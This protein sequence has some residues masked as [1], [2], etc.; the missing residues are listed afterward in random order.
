MIWVWIIAAIAIS[1]LLCRKKVAWYHYIWMLLPV[2]MYGITIAGATIKP[3]MILGVF[4]IIKNLLDRKA[5]KVPAAFVAIIFLLSV[6]DI[7]NGLIIASIMQHVMFLVI[8]YIAYNYVLISENDDDLLENIEVST[9]ATTIGYGLVFLVAYWF[10]SRG[11]GFGGIY[12]TDRYSAGMLLNFISTGGQTTVRLRGFCIDPNSVVTTLIPGA[13]FGL[14]RLLYKNGGKF[15]SLVAVIL[16]AIVM[17]LSGSRMAVVCTVAMVIIM[18]MMGYKQAENKLWWFGLIALV[19]LV[20]SFM[21][22]YRFQNIA[23]EVYSFFTA[24]AGLN[25][26]GGRF[27]IWKYNARWLSDNGRLLFGVGQNQISNLTSVG[28]ACHNTWLEW[29]CGTGIL[30]GG[31]IDLWFVITPFVFLDRLKRNRIFIRDII[32]IVLAYVT[33]LICIT[34]VDNITNS[35]VLFLMVIFRYGNY[36]N[37]TLNRDQGL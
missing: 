17:D 27:T 11:I 32:P 25:D 33:A 6:S 30:L 28:K 18:L 23:S 35:V 8:I 3:Y 22:V 26:T 36:I 24:R 15:R 5:H 20:V 9:I 37:L 10:Y 13:S 19:L 4:M 7:L 2:E 31:M 1:W 34:T 12:T 16:Y 21:A 14:A 29:I